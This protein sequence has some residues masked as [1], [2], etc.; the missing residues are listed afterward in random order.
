MHLQDPSFQV[1]YAEQV[2]SMSLVFAQPH[3]M[4]ICG[5]AVKPVLDVLSSFY[6]RYNTFT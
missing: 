2:S 3:I 1:H 5:Y 6:I 4:H